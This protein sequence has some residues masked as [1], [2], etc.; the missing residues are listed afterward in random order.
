MRK[1]VKKLRDPKYYGYCESWQ[2]HELAD[3]FESD[4]ALDAYIEARRREFIEDWL[5]YVAEFED[6][7]DN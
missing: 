6:D 1:G 4:E 2:K 7:W 5:I 3:P